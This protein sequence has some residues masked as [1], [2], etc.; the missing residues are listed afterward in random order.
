ME[1][2]PMASAPRNAACLLLLGDTI[3]DLDDV[4]VGCFCSGDEMREGQYGEPGLYEQHGAWMIWNDC[5]DWFFIGAYEPLGWFP[6]PSRG[7]ASGMRLANSPA[8][9]IDA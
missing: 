2:Q 1:F 9:T 4:R 6:L 5:S 7:S 3:P 8:I